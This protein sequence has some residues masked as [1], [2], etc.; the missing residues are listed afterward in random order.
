MNYNC[1]IHKKNNIGFQIFQ[2]R[3]YFDKAQVPEFGI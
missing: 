3:I 2:N 1:D